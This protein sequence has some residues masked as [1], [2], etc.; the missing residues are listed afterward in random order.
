M[1][2]PTSGQCSGP[3]PVSGACCKSQPEASFHCET[4]QVANAE[5]IIVETL[6]VESSTLANPEHMVVQSHH[7]DEPMALRL[8]RAEDTIDW[9]VEKVEALLAKNAS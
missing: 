5:S 1:I 7:F 9:L 3:D 2:D 6:T 4:T 8:E